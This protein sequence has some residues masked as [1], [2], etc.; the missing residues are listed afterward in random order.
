MKGI[1]LD[2]DY[3]LQVAV[4]RN[5]EGLISESIVVGDI[6]YQNQEIIIKTEKGELKEAPLKGVGALSFVDDDV[7]DNFLREIRVQLT[8]E[9]MKVNRV[10]FNNEGKL[11]IDANY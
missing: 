4:K 10:K 1:L 11:I 8:Q 6:T 2:N 9:G 3:E 5:S 7:P